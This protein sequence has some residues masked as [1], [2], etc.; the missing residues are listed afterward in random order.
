MSTDLDKLKELSA[1]P[2]AE[3]ATAFMNVYWDRFFTE[4]KECEELWKW[5]QIFIS[6]DK[7]KEK[8]C[9]LNEFDAH[10]FLESI[11]ETLSVKDMRE[12]LRSVD[13]DFNKMVS[14]TEYLVSKFKVKW[15]EYVSTPP[16]MDKKRMAELE[17]ARTS[18]AAVTLTLTQNPNS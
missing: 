5:T 7:K 12:F 16:G 13:I 9:E 2:Y 18:V 4:E 8:G 6:L 1:K 11:N 10:R 17:A 14:L 3:Q 15:K